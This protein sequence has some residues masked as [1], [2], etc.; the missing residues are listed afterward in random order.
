MPVKVVKNGIDYFLAP[1]PTVTIGKTYIQNIGSG[2]IGSEYTINLNG[3]ILAWKGN[4]VASGSTPVVTN[5]SDTIYGNFSSD[6]DPINTTL[7]SSGY[8]NSII[9]KQERIRELFTDNGSGIQL[10]IIPFDNSGSGIS[11]YCTLENLEF[12]DQSRWT[13]TCGY[14]ASLRTSRFINSANSGLFSNSTE[15]NFTYYISEAQNEWSISESDSYTASTGNAEAQQKLYTIGHNA[16]AVGQRTFTSSGLL[17][18]V[19]QASGYV[20]NVIGLGSGGLPANFLGVPSGYS[21]YNRTISEN[22]N[23]FT[24]SYAVDEQFTLGP[25]GQAAT[26]TI[27][28]IIEN[29]LSPL[30]RVSIQG[31]IAGFNTNS[32]TGKTVN[33]FE[34]ATTYWNSV[35]GV[36][37]NRANN[38]VNGCSLNSIPLSRSIGKNPQEGTISYS[39]NYDNRPANLVTGSLTED[40]QISDTYPGQNINVVPVIGRSQPII[41][42]LNSRSE[43]KRSLQVNITMPLNGNC[44]PQKPSSQEIQTKIYDV[45]KPIA[46]RVYHSSPVESWNPKTGQYSYNIE[47]TFE[48]PSDQ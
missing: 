34:N 37:Y 26:E 7:A 46:F 13:N 31:S 1:A 18:P 4:P 8:L 9:R 29:D 42:Y 16:S 40:I 44:L 24:G 15:D 14:T 47:W 6:D 20:H 21:V 28:V 39:L 35:S 33:K 27:Q 10:H 45:Y 3:T 22:I 30:T 12:D 11:A 2:V 32:V 19:A 17:N 5:S 43:Y 41:Q 36:L 38:Y 23:P 48:G 25:S